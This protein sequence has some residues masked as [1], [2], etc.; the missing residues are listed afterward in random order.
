MKD[1]YIYKDYI[2]HAEYIYIYTYIKNIYLTKNMYI[3]Q[4]YIH[5]KEYMHMRTTY[6]PYRIYTHT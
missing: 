4:E 1:I 2:H 3:Y 6:T 5:N